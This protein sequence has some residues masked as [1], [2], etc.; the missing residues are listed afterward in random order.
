MLKEPASGKLTYQS[1]GN[2]SF[3]QMFPGSLHEQ[4]HKSGEDECKR[5]YRKYCYIVMLLKRPF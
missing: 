2:L 1:R 5:L 3:K 4:V